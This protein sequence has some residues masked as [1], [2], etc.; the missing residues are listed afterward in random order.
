MAES[1]KLPR[2]NQQK[3][4]N[5]AYHGRK[6]YQYPWEGYFCPS[7]GCLVGHER[8]HK[9]YSEYPEICHVDSIIFP[10]GLVTLDLGYGPAD[11]KRGKLGD[12]AQRVWSHTIDMSDR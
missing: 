5:T 12:V 7:A 2:I 3:I 6:E 8:R 9:T 4:Q 1:S 10:L 11:S